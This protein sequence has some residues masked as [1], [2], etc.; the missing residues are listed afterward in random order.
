MGSAGPAADEHANGPRPLVH[1]RPR[2]P[3]RTGSRSSDDQL[4]ENRR[5]A[6]RR[7]P[8]RLQTADR[9]D[10]ACGSSGS[11]TARPTTGLAVYLPLAHAPGGPATVAGEVNTYWID[12]VLPGPRVHRSSQQPPRGHSRRARLRRSRRRSPTTATHDNVAV[13][14]QDHDSRSPCSGCV[15]V[16][17]SMVGL[18]NAITMGMLERTR[19]IGMLR[20]VGARARDVRRIFGPKASSW[21][22]SDGCSASRS[23]TRSRA[24]SSP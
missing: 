9:P 6:G 14:R 11:A 3:G 19:E 18:V 10:A 16:A 7:H 15:I 22:C 20:S 8:S 4:A 21:P 2:A 23:A 24:G 1:A 12:H 13:Q 17:I 5:R